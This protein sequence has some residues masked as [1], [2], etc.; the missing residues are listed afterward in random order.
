MAIPPLTPFK[1]IRNTRSSVAEEKAVLCR[2]LNDVLRRVPRSIGSASVQSVRAWQAAHKA[3]KKVL[4]SKASSVQ[5]LASALS[6]ME[7]FE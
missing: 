3:A 6:S 2:R 5:Q 4:E 1:D 7:R